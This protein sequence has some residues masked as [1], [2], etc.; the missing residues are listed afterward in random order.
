[1]ALVGPTEDGAERRDT[2]AGAT[3]LR[4]SALHG[5]NPVFKSGRAVFKSGRGGLTKANSKF[6]NETRKSPNTKV[7]GHVSFYNFPEGRYVFLHRL[8]R[9]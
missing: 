5:S 7:V 3:A 9:K 8:P 6:L 2:E 1:V 4:E